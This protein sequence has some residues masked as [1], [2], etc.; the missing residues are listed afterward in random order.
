MEPGDGGAESDDPNADAASRAPICVE[1]D[2]F[3]VGYQTV[4]TLRR[5]DC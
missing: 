5:G 1:V 3:L 2:A 4:S